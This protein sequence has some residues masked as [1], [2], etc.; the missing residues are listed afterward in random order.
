V[1]EKR[2]TRAPDAGLV[3]LQIDVLQSTRRSR[4]DRHRKDID[5]A[6]RRDGG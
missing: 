2:P 3:T 4:A 1:I 5:P 6:Q